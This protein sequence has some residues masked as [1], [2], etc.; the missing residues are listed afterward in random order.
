[1]VRPEVH[2]TLNEADLGISNL[3]K[4]CHRVGSRQVLLERRLSRFDL[5]DG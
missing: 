5:S 3:L 2:K 4:A 1:M